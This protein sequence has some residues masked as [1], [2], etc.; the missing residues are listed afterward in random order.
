MGGVSDWRDEAQ[1]CVNSPDNR[2]PQCPPPLRSSTRRELAASISPSA[3]FKLPTPTQPRSA[4]KF[5]LVSKGFG[6][7]KRTSE[8]GHQPEFS[9]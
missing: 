7:A 5:L 8:T 6:E 1:S 4:Q 2:F 3:T 9:L